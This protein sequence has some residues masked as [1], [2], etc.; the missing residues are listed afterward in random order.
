MNPRCE[1]FQ[2]LSTVKSSNSITESAFVQSPTFPGSLKVS[3]FASSTLLPS[4]QTV[5]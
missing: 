3:S 4:Y 2:R 5:K 1:R